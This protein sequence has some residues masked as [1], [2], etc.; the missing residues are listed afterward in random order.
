MEEL[1]TNFSLPELEYRFGGKRL[2]EDIRDDERDA[3]WRMVGDII[4]HVVRNGGS[5]RCDVSFPGVCLATLEDVE[6]HIRNLRVE[7]DTVVVE[8]E[9]YD[10]IRNDSIYV[11][12]PDAIR[13]IHG[14]LFGKKS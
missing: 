7:D 12:K 8:C 14:A 11:Y 2:S 4:G 6:E 9:C 3:V 13:E 10:E 1:D 5:V